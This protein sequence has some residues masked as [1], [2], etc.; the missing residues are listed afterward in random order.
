M[1]FLGSRLMALRVGLLIL[2]GRVEASTFRCNSIAAAGA[3][4][5]K[6]NWVPGGPKCNCSL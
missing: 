1:I 4:N 3:L 5:R 6:C 2:H